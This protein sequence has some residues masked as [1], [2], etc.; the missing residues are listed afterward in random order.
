MLI[1]FKRVGGIRFLT[2]GR[3]RLSFC[4]AS[5]SPAPKVRKASRAQAWRAG[6][7]QAKGEAA[8]ASDARQSIP[9]RNMVDFDRV[10]RG[11]DIG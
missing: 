11:L 8:R 9:M 5:A 10:M 2:I 1:S 6:Y 7:Y 3:L 4:I